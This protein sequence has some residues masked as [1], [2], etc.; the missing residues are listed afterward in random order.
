M[1]SEPPTG[2]G[3]PGERDRRRLE[4]LIPEIV[5]RVLD[6]GYD[7]ISEGPENVRAFVSDLKLPKE[8]LNLLLAQ[9]E[10]TKTGL[11]RVVAKEIRDF[12]EHAD[13]STELA[14]VLTG[15]TLEI[16]TQVRFLPSDTPGTDVKTQVKVHRVPEEDEETPP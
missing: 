12:L 5:K 1:Q 16:K 3:E 15:M 9:I 14:K 10:E 2:D 11:H 8:A 6:L 13:F 7:K 4:R